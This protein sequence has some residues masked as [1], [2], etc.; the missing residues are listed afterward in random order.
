MYNLL[1]INYYIIYVAFSTKQDI[2][3]IIIFML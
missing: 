3:H 2:G 1:N